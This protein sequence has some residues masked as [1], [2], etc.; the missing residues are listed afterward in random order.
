MDWQAVRV[1]VWQQL[2]K[3]VPVFGCFSHWSI[4]FFIITVQLYFFFGWPMI[5]GDLVIGTVQHRASVCQS[6]SDSRLTIG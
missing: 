6:L 2:A 5:L 4:I 1:T 3:F